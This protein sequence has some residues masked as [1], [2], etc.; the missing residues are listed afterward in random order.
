MTAYGLHTSDREDM[1][2]GW[3]YI[4]DPDLR[5][6]FEGQRRIAR[7]E[8]QEQHVYCEILYADHRDIKRFNEHFEPTLS[9]DDNDR[10]ILI[11][12]WYRKLLK[13]PASA[14]GTN[15]RIRITAANSLICYGMACFQHPQIVV[16]LATALAFIGTGLGLIGVGLA[17]VGWGALGLAVGILIIVIGIV[18]GA[19]GVWA[20]VTRARREVQRPSP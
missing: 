20:F 5:Q 9:Y 17:I 13:I 18:I 11:N 12:G 19:I 6:R 3:I 8:Y 2:E 7:V 4:R 14:I 10:I 16:L 15:I 1:N